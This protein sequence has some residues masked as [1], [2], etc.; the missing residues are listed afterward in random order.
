M[1]LIMILMFCFL[2]IGLRAEVINVPDDYATI[3]EGIEV[4]VDGDSVLV[5]PG[6]YYE[7]I[8]FMGKGITVCSWYATTQDTSYISETVIDGGG[9][10]S[11]VRFVS[12]EDSLSVLSG[13]T[14]CNGYAQSGGGIFCWQGGPSIENLKIINNH[15]NGGGG[16]INI[17]DSGA[18]RVINTKISNNTAT[19]GGGICVFSCNYNIILEGLEIRDNQAIYGGGLRISSE[20]VELSNVLIKG[21]QVETYGGGIYIDQGELRVS[22]SKILDNVTEESGGGIAVYSLMNAELDLDDVDIRSNRA[23]YKGGGIYCVDIGE[24]RMHQTSISGN[25]ASIGGGV[26][27]S[28]T[29]PDL[30]SENRNSIYQNNGSR[31]AAADM[32]LCCEALFE[33][34]LDTFTVAYPTEYH[35]C[36]MTPLQYDFLH[37][38]QEQVEGDLYVSPFGDNANNGLSEQYPLKTI[39]YACSVILANEEN[40]RT[41]NLLPGVYSSTENNETFPIQLPYHVSLCGIERSGVILDAEGNSG[42]MRMSGLSSYHEISN[43]TIRNGCAERGGGIVNYSSYFKLENVALL[44]NSASWGGGIYCVYGSFGLENVT[45]T[46]CSAENGSAIYSRDSF[47]DY[48]ANSLIWNNRNDDL[49]LESLDSDVLVIYSDIGGGLEA[50]NHPYYVNWLEGNIDED[51]LFLDPANGSYLLQKASPCIDAGTTYFEYEGEVLIDLSEDEYYGDAPDMG[52]FEYGMVETDEVV[53]ENEKLKIEN[54]PNPFNPETTIFFST[55]EGTENSELSIYNIK[56]QCLRSFKIQN[57][58]S[59]INQVVWDG[60]N[61]NG[62]LVSSGVYLVRVQSNNEIASKKIMLIK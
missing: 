58:K 31:A 5:A 33:V 57:S 32:D 4:A 42:V 52:A 15:S 60:R 6:T 3:Q 1:K 43:L 8:N 28:G 62:R 56:G 51:P 55:T 47:A 41:I 39:Q 46:G 22:S 11:V 17:S 37:V 18:T 54:Y 59:K 21:N 61:E 48:I 35:V 53:I 14:I 20:S 24:F 45:I 34:C 44:N 7:N 27:I 16:G 49:F 12:G 50:I 40:P 9:I 29:S 26:S 25:S 36:S 19:N 23:E 38:M 13:F 2:A 30:D 10:D